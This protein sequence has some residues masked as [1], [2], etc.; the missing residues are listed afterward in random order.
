M[1]VA[2][3]SEKAGVLLRSSEKKTQK[4]E[5][6]SARRALLVRGAQIEVRRKDLF[7]IKHDGIA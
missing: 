7:Y 6:P 3:S 4:G 5:G 1:L 2:K